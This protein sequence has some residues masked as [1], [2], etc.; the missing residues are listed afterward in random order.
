VLEGSDDSGG[1]DERDQRGCPHPRQELTT[2]QVEMA[3]H[4]QVRKVGKR[5]EQG[6]RVGEQEAPVKQRWS[7]SA[8]A[9]CGVHQHGG[10]EGYRRVQVQQRS[11]D[12]DHDGGPEEQDH[13]ARG[14]PG[15]LVPSGGE[16]A[17]IVSD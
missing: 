16:Q 8:S 6:A 4:D 9:A 2:A 17:V 12:A 1:H 10:E 15:E 13:A 11:H 14:G 3:K 7:T 5:Q